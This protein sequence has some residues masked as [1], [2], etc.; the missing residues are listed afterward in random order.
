MTT[1]ESLKRDDN[2][3]KET[4]PKKDDNQRQETCPKKYENQRKRDDNQR[5]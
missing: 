1:K 2:Q 4:C 3:R 5:E